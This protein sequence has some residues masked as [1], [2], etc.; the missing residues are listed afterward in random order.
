MERQRFGKIF[1]P[2][3]QNGKVVLTQITQ[4]N[5]ERLLSERGMGIGVTYQ[6]MFGVTVAQKYVL[7]FSTLRRSWEGHYIANVS[8]AGNEEHH[9]LK[10]KPEA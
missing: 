6:G 3:A 9:P 8:H 7:K 10:A 5:A 4:K 1:T 2:F